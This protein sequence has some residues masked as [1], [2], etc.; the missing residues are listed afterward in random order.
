MVK[1]KLKEVN[2]KLGDIMHVEK[3][4]AKKIGERK[5]RFL[6]HKRT[7]EISSRDLVA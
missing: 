3:V 4:R 7:V 2:K 6:E 5:T 1:Q